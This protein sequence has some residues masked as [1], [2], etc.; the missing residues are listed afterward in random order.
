MWRCT[1]RR[2]QKWA[3]SPGDLSRRE[4][5]RLA[6]IGWSKH[7]NRRP[8]HTEHNRFTP[9][10]QFVHWARLEHQQ[11]PSLRQAALYLHRPQL[12]RPQSYNTLCSEWTTFAGFLTPL[13]S[14]L[15]NNIL[16][17]VTWN[18]DWR[19][20]DPAT[21]AT[22]AMRHLESI[23]TKR[24]GLLVVMLQEVCQESLQALRNNPWVQENFV[25]TDSTLSKSIHDEVVG[26]SFIMR[27]ELSKP[28]PH[29][30]IML[31]PK[32]LRILS[33]FRVPLVT[34]MGRDAL[35]ADISVTD[36]PQAREAMRL[37]TTHLDSLPGLNPHRFSQLAMIS[38]L[39]KEPR[40]S[41]HE[42]IAGVVG[43]DMGATESS[44]RSMHKAPRVS[45]KDVWEDAPK[46]V[47]P[48][49]EPGEEDPT[50]GRARGN[51]FGYQSG[52]RSPRK[53]LSKFF[54]TGKVDSIALSEPLVQDVT[55]KLGRVGI[56]CKTAVGAWM[57]QREL[58]SAVYGRM[59]CT[60]HKEILSDIQASR[61][62]IRDRGLVEKI[63]PVLTNFWVSGHFGIAVGIRICG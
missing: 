44:D 54:Y 60:S 48:E 29:F 40:I 13:G 21:R 32:T 43:G 41:E 42:N 27:E 10:E 1:E 17:I 58:R 53:R 22:A 12:L 31:L 49:L 50:Y 6:F 63:R 59:V 9:P 45:L 57:V 18:L 24:P 55:G 5:R 56:G 52:Y 8:S 25:M 35:V 28:A 30:T 34:A 15:H 39:L 51:T 7:F 47:L 23:F 20:P 3:M 36:E 38:T 4:N 33:C 16:K 37:C 14:S 61:V 2:L 19:L 62:K 11:R 26:D 46:Q